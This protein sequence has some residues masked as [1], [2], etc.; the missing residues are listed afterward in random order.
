M[1]Y[2]VLTHATFDGLPNAQHIYDQ[3]KSVAT[4]ASVAKIGE[5]GERTSYCG[6]YE[7]QIDGTLTPLSQWH[8][9]RFGILRE[10][11]PIANDVVPEW[12][13]PTGA[14]DAYPLLDVFGLPAKVMYNGSEW[15]NTSAVNTNAPGVF[16]WTDLSVPVEPEVSAG[17]PTWT[18]W[19][20]GLNG[21]LYQVGN[22]VSHNGSDWRATTGN[23]YWEP[24][25][26]GWVAI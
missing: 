19:T 18:P 25:V 10:T 14:Q 12:V 17:L 21:D 22:E 9:D 11:D 13:Q 20:T 8:I 15:E 24:G 5:A 7:E 2:V 23:N 26:F 1:P 16:G 4:N 6:V 3:A